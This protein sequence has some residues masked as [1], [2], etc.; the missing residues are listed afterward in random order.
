VVYCCGLDSLCHYLCDIGNISLAHKPLEKVLSAAK[1]RSHLFL[2]HLLQKSLCLVQLV[3][4]GE[5]VLN[6][7]LDIDPVSGA[8]QGFLE[9]HVQ[10][11]LL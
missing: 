10:L 1:L 11:L 8:E 6:D 4:V 2:L 3:E 9:S 7:A 5:G